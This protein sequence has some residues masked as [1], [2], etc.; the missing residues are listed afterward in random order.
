MLFPALLFVVVIV[1]LILG[2]V[3][4]IK[5]K[6]SD[7]L[8]DWRK[9]DGIEIGEPADARTLP[10]EGLIANVLPV[11]KPPSAYSRR[12]FEEHQHIRDRIKV[13]PKDCDHTKGGRDRRIRYS[14]NDYN[15]SM[16]T[17]I[18]GTQRV[19]CLTCGQKWFESDKGWA[20]AI[21]MVS[22]STN[23]QTSS[24]QLSEMQ[25]VRLRK[26]ARGKGP[27]PDRKWFRR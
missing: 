15:V 20:E 6:P 17:F 2:D 23:R 16:M 8:L 3:L 9:D 22:E 4:F 14:R 24:E 12:T 13:D 11:V 27:K 10:V 21:R 26:E 25:K 19:R 18:D 1:L 5:P 7:G